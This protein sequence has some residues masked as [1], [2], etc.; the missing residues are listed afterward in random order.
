DLKE[1]LNAL[2]SGGTILVEQMLPEQLAALKKLQ[3]Y[4]LRVAKKSF[5]LEQDVI[6]PVAE[7]IE[8]EM[9]AREIK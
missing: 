3:D 9:F 5:A 4:E 2:T 7:K 6:D 8:K 1:R